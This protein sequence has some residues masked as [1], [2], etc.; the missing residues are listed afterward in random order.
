MIG[1]EAALEGRIGQS[2][3]V[4]QSQGGKIYCTCSV[5]VDNG[6]DEDPQWVSII[7]FGAKAEALG[8]LGKGTRVYLE[9]RLSLNSF[10]RQNGV[11]VTGLKLIANTVQP[12]DQIGHR[13][14]KQPRKPAGALDWQ[15]PLDR[16]PGEMDQ[17]IP[18]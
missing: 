9:G 14:L 12:L 5:A 3:D 4:R 7:A 1:I 10:T 8:T 2:P 16:T 6:K 15:R 11:E 18:F 13:K 17:A